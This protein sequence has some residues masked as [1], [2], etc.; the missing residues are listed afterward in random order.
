MCVF[1][2]CLIRNINHVA[3]LIKL[4]VANL[5][6]VH[7]YNWNKFI[8]HLV[9]F[10]PIYRSK[11]NNGLKSVGGLPIG[12]TGYSNLMFEAVGSLSFDTI[13]PIFIIKDLA[14]ASVV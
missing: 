12:V 13:S 6:Y 7:I 8:T 4:A 9:G 5:S 11:I 1:I 14:I 2:S 10:T 3:R